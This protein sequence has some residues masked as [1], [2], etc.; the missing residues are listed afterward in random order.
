MQEILLFFEKYCFNKVWIKLFSN[1]TINI[2]NNP[3][4]N[5]EPIA[6][7]L[8]LTWV[9]PSKVKCNPLVQSK[10]SYFISF[11]VMNVLILLLSYI[12]FRIISSVM[13]RGKFAKRETT[14]N[15]TILWPLGTFW[16]L[17]KLIKLL[18]L[19]IMYWFLP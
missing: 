11:L 10:I 19:F 18:V 1:S 14:S 3:G 17:M 13:S 15:K 16:R 6:T 4:P 7:P 2:P 12:R 5:G 9:L 8:V